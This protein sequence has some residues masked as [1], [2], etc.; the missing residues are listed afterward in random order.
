VG[1]RFLRDYGI[2]HNDLKPQNVLLKIMSDRSKANS[3]F[4]LRLIDFG[5]SYS[6]LQTQLNRTNRYKRGFTIPYAAPEQTGPE[7]RFTEKIDIFGFGVML[8]EIVFDVF[9]VEVTRKGKEVYLTDENYL[10][11][12]S[13]APEKCKYYCLPRMMQLL[14]H[15]C[16]RCLSPHPA[17]R[18]VIDWVVAI[19]REVLLFGEKAYQY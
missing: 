5:E 1:L 12:Y 8:Y 15:L 6:T 7:P 4:M 11:F 9:P 3:T 2:I 10:K 19:I 16:L 13:M 18:P 17:H 14:Y